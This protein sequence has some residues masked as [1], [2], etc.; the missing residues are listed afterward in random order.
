MDDAIFKEAAR[1]TLWYFVAFLINVFGVQGVLKVSAALA[2]KASKATTGS[3]VAFNR[4]TDVRILA[5]DRCVGNFVEWMGIFL[6]LFWVNAALTGRNID[7]GWMYVA[8]R[9]LY[10]VLALSGGITPSGPK[11]LIFFA[12]MPGY[13]VLGLYM[14]QIYNAL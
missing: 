9:L 8:S 5:G 1:I 12:T 10:P 14:I 4:Y 6:A 13:Y 11:P 7:Y 2:H 3:K